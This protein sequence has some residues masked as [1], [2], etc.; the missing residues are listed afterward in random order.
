MIIAGLHKNSLID[1][2][3]KVSCVVFLTGCNLR[4]PYCHNPDLA[5]GLSPAPMQVEELLAF[6]AQRRNWLDGVVISGGEPTLQ[7]GL[8]DLCRS[9]RELGL[10]LKLDTNGSRPEVLAELLQEDLLDFVA[11]DIK[12]APEHYAPAFAGRQIGARVLRSIRLL[13]ESA[14]RYEFRTTCVRPFVDDDIITRIA[15]TVRGARHYTLQH[16]QST[17]L[18]NEEYFEGRSPAMPMVEM[19][20]LQSLMAPWV[21]CCQIR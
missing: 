13:M 12:T 9:V 2:P 21:E 4:C 3:G 17:C 18:L 10:A 14:P 11:M 7:A 16:F 19:T 6:L 8:G 20:R 1:F 15:Q 5:Q